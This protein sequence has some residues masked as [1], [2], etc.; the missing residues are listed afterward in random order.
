ML[1][2]LLCLPAAAGLFVG[3]GR[4]ALMLSWTMT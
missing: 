4:W 2:L 1:L 3:V